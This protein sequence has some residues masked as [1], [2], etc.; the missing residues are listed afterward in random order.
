MDCPRRRPRSRRRA[1][2]TAL[3]EFLEETGVSLQRLRFFETVT[4]VEVPELLPSVLHVFF[5]DDQVVRENI[6][7]NEGLTSST[8]TR[9]TSLS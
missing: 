1:R 4:P 5:A 7:V 8:S 6:E 2:D 9:R 3:R